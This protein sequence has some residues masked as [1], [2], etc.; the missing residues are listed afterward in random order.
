MQYMT[1]MQPADVTS[2]FLQDKDICEESLTQ[3]HVLSSLEAELSRSFLPQRAHDFLRGRY[4]LKT[5]LQQEM[6]RPMQD[7]AIIPDTAGKPKISGHP[8]LYCSI[9]HTG[10]WVAA[11][12]SCERPVGIDIETVKPRH[13]SLLQS[14]AS[15]LEIVSCA[16][17]CEPSLVTTTLWSIKEAVQKADSEIYPMSEYVITFGKIITVRRSSNIWQASVQ[18]KGN[19]IGAVAVLA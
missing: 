3:A 16:K 2:V 1:D 17:V 15:Q 8:E 18:T 11:A 6:L 9:S 5:L 12:L 13:P 4:A 7:I 19:C 10:T 14:I